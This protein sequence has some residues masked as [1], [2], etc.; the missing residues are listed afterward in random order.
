MPFLIS[1]RIARSSDHR[2]SLARNVSSLAAASLAIERRSHR[3]SDPGNIPTTFPS[4]ASSSPTRSSAEHK[5]LITSLQQAYGSIHA[6]NNSTDWPEA[7]L[8]QWFADG[9]NL[10]TRAL[11]MQPP[12]PLTHRLIDDVGASMPAVEL[13]MMD[14]GASGILGALHRGGDRR[15]LAELVERLVEHD[16]VA[17]RLGLDSDVIDGLLSEGE[18]AWPFMRPGEVRSA[19][20]GR[21]HAGISPSG[22]PRGDRHVLV[23][24]L[25]DEATPAGGGGGGGDLS[26]WPSLAT[27]DDALGSVAAAIAAQLRD[28][29]NDDAWSHGAA[30]DGRLGA[31]RRRSDTFLACFPG[32]GLGYGAHYDGDEHCRLTMLLYTTRLWQPEHGGALRLLDEARGVWHVVPPREN[33]LV[34]FRSDKVLH[35]VDPCYE[36]KKRF[37]LTVF[38]SEG[39]STSEAE[40]AAMLSSL[41]F[42]V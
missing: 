41:A 5:R 10:T 11:S 32:D 1:R 36:R 9:G 7:L 20:D 37:A 26:C 23:R 19:S 3:R 15:P 33:T 8:Q 29:S 35:R 28:E 17:T 25:A 21:I 22:S 40:R 16:C 24:D 39:M 30:A 27:A 18:K 42:S 6:P 2:R 31:L 4:A 12:S 14:S 13:E 34:I 38:V